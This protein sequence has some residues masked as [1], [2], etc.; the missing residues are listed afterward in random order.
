MKGGENLKQL[1][2]IVERAET[3]TGNAAQKTPLGGDFVFNNLIV[4]FSSKFVA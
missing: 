3:D 2:S 4:Q 1:D